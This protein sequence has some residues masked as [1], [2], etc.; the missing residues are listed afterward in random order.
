MYGSVERNP[1]SRRDAAGGGGRAAGSGGVGGEGRV[2]LDEPLLDCVAAAALLGV[3]VSWMRDAARLGQVPCLR[4]GRHIRFSRSTLE[5]WLAGQERQAPSAATTALRAAQRNRRV[6]S[7]GRARSE[8]ERLIA[9]LESPGSASE[10]E[11]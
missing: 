4:L 10:T 5:A 9:A 11:V 1:G 7:P 6:Y 2:P 8:R 3:R